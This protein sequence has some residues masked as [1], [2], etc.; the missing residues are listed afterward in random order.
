MPAGAFAPGVLEGVRSLGQ[1]VKE[2]GPRGRAMFIG[3]WAGIAID[4][5]S[6]RL[7]GA[8]TGELPSHAEG[9]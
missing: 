8:G 4:P 5:Q 6:G 7:R 9:Y 3:Y 2:L 1:E